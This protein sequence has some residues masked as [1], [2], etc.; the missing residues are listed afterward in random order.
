MHGAPLGDTFAPM[1]HVPQCSGGDVGVTC[2]SRAALALW[3]VLA[4]FLGDLPLFLP[5]L[6]CDTH[7]VESHPR[8]PMPVVQHMAVP[9]WRALHHWAVENGP[10][11]LGSPFPTCIHLPPAAPPRRCRCLWRLSRSPPAVCRGSGAGPV[12]VPAPIPRG[13]RQRRLLLRRSGPG[14][15]PGSAGLW[16]RCPIPVPEG[17]PV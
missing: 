5:R 6:L 16:Q 7:G 1:W 2:L 8:W 11:A 3:L 13:G 14:A 10:P 15:G 17:D 12:P 9:A 4:G